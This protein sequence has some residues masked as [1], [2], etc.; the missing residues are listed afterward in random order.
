[1]RH[2]ILDFAT[3]NGMENQRTIK[4][5]DFV[6]TGKKYVAVAGVIIFGR[7]CCTSNESKQ[8]WINLEL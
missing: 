5:R 8:D 7:T 4:T 1:M 6:R 2:I 3:R